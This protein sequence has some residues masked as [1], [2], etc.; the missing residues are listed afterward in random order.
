MSKNS[1][2][3]KRKVQDM[4]CFMEQSEKR[5]E[6][7]SQLYLKASRYISVE[8]EQ[9]FEKYKTK[10]GLTDES[11]RVLLNTLQDKTSLDQLKEALRSGKSDKTKAELLALLESPAYQARLERLKQLQNQ[12][13]MVMN[14]VYQQEK[15]VNTNHYLDLAN[16]AYYRS[17]FQVQQQTGLA[18][19]FNLID[20]KVIDR[21]LDS[22][23]SGENYS[24]RIW[25]NTNALAQNLKEELLFN[26]ITGRTERETAEIIANKYAVGAG[27]ARRL[28]RTESCFVSCQMDM[29]G[30]K[31]CGLERYRFLA[32]LDL[33]TSDICRS[34]DGKVFLVSEQIPGVNCPPMHPW[35]RST[36]IVIISDGELRYLQ[37]RARDP[38]TG[39]TR[40]LPANMTYEQWYKKHVKGHPEAEIN[41]NSI[42]YRAQ[43]RKQYSRYKKLLGSNAPDNLEDFQKIKYNKDGSFEQLQEAYR[44]E[45]KVVSFKEKLK[46]GEVNLTIKSQKQ[47]E[48]IQGTKKWRQRVKQD[49][50]AKGTA[51]DMFYKETN[52]SELVKMYSGTGKIEFRKGQQFPIEYISSQDKIGKAF[53]LGAGKYIDTKRF[54]IRY[55]S[56]GVHL[57]PVKE[58]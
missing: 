52:V 1:Y 23:W 42:K 58:V 49:L 18:F 8:S 55:S 19:S 36:T 27:K 50:E 5:A 29:E 2:W 46:N 44:N 37:R 21:I 51:P 34:L 20:S 45:K 35:C 53:D 32:T 14:Q 56:K 41:E 12:L 11:A 30:Y 3:E 31:E 40:T 38:E 25:K 54:A 13:D 33:V 24:A 28:V 48:H 15:A 10:H 7:L 4:F 26:L 9:I 57:H 43:D 17:I 22:K 6:E 47:Q 39:K 16:E